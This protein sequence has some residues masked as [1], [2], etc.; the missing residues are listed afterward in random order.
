MQWFGLLLMV[1]WGIAKEQSLH[2]DSM[3]FQACK[4]RKG[5]NYER[6]KK[7]RNRSGRVR[8]L[9]ADESWSCYRWTTLTEPSAS[10]GI[11]PK[12]SMDFC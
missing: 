8:C 1:R 4:K 3:G 5:V 11:V 12:R 6:P 10:A 7:Q 9:R 2:S